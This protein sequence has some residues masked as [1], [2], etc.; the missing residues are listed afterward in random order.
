MGWDEVTA[1][2]T[3]V[4]ALATAYAAFAAASAARHSAA[5]A[6]RDAERWE[7]ER[8]EQ[9]IAR[10][11]AQYVRLGDKTALVVENHGP[12]VAGELRLELDHELSQFDVTAVPTSLAPGLVLELPY[13]HTMGLSHDR[14]T[15]VHW[16]DGAGNRHSLEVPP[17]LVS[18]TTRQSFREREAVLRDLAW[19]LR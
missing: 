1:L 14:K 3:A 13:F 9:L 5:I 10:V 17:Q 18:A 4:A 8:Q 15:A 6:D 11:I 16:V 2:G 19:R 7:R 12:A